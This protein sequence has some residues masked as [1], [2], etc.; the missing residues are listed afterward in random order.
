[1]RSVEL[2]RATIQSFSQLAFFANIIPATI[3]ITGAAPVTKVYDGTSFATLVAGNYTLTGFVG[4]DN[5]TLTTT[6][7]AYNSPD[8]ATATTANFIGWVS[9][10]PA[11][12][13][14]TIL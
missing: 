14:P 12:W 13:R 6:G 8:V 2:R 9:M 5:A 4:T 10:S 11:A 1:M 7:G 3:T